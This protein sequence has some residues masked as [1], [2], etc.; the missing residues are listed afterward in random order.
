MWYY[1]YIVCVASGGRRITLHTL[2]CWLV[3]VIHSSYLKF[4]VMGPGRCDRF[5]R[6]DTDAWSL[7]LYHTIWYKL[8]GHVTVLNDIIWTA[9][10]FYAAN[11]LDFRYMANR[12]FVEGLCSE[13]LVVVRSPSHEGRLTKCQHPFAKSDASTCAWGCHALYASMPPDVLVW[14]ALARHSC[15][16]KDGQCL[17]RCGCLRRPHFE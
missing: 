5:T 7:G 10:M 2:L 14:L 4:A 17:L 12:R 9:C 11:I 15:H 16:S 13:T 8:C 3:Q 1:M 6:F